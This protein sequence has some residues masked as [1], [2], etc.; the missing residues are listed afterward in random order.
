M[1]HFIDSMLA[2][3]G[4]CLLACLIWPFAIVV[5]ALVSWPMVVMGL[6]LT[7]A[8]VAWVAAPLSLGA[9]LY[10]HLKLIVSL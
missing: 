3:F 10:L 4:T 5:V 8:I 7:P 2:A 1:G 6:A 9:A